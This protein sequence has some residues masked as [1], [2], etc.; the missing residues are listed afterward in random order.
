MIGVARMVS[1]IDVN[2]N[3]RHWSLLSFS[4]SPMRVLAR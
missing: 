4:L 1:G 2:P 3:G